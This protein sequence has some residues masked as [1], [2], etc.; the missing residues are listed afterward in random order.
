MAVVFSLTLT[1]LSPLTPAAALG[2]GTTSFASLAQRIGFLINNVFAFL[3]P[4]NVKLTTL[5]VSV[6]LVT[7]D[8]I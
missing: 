8:T 7:R 1:T 2:T 5:M 4:T 3:S 6:N